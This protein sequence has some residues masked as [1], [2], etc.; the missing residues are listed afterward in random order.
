MDEFLLN[1]SDVKVEKGLITF[2]VRATEKTSELK[3]VKGILVVDR[4]GYEVTIPVGYSTGFRV[5]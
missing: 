3:S 4:K 5:K 2:P 1:H